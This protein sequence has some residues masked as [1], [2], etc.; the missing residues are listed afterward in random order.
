M[1]AVALRNILSSNKSRKNE[2]ISILSKE[3]FSLEGF[4]SYSQ[5]LLARIVLF[6]HFLASKDTRKLNIWFLSSTVENSIFPPRWTMGK[7]LQERHPG[8][9]ATVENSKQVQKR[10][11]PEI[12]F[13]KSF[14]KI[15]AFLA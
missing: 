4:P 6:A 15:N 8:V 10:V 11:Y 12:L 5:I 2:R 3:E 7:W 9:S 13:I 1:A 14:T